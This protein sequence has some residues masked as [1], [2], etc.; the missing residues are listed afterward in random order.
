[1]RTYHLPLPRLRQR[2]GVQ[3]SENLML[4]ESRTYE[5]L[6]YSR[7]K[8][9][10]GFLDLFRACQSVD[11]RAGRLPELALVRPLNRPLTK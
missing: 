7:G 9:A 8:D 10:V 2:S 1:M 5:T 4:V 11:W 3:P 6:A